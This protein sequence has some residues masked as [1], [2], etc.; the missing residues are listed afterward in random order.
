MRTTVDIADPIL[1]EVKRLK[2]KEE[3]TLGAVVSE[4]LVEGLAARKKRRGTEKSKPFRWI[5]KDLKPRVD[6]QDKE[7]LWAIFDEESGYPHR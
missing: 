1:E 3:K 5:S 6:L 7:A 4:L 2:E